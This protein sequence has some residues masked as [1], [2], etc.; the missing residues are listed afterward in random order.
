MSEL[1]LSTA[2]AVTLT[3]CGGGGVIKQVKKNK[4]SSFSPPLWKHHNSLQVGKNTQG[5]C[6]LGFVLG[7]I[8]NCNRICPSREEWVWRDRAGEER[9]DKIV[10]NMSKEENKEV[11]WFPQLALAAEKNHL[12]LF[13]LLARRWHKLNELSSAIRIQLNHIRCRVW[14]VLQIISP[15]LCHSV[16]CTVVTYMFNSTDYTYQ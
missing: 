12:F 15:V 5:F 8:A 3:G 4:C 7:F 2:R 11:I 14:L 16:T 1:C 10:S 6:N 13:V 9:F